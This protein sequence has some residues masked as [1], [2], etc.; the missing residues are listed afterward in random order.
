M[1]NPAGDLKSTFAYGLSRQRYRESP[2]SQSEMYLLSVNKVLLPT[3]SIALSGSRENTSLDG[4]KISTRNRYTFYTDA[5]LY[6]DLTSQLEAVYWDLKNFDYAVVNGNQ[7]N[8]NTKMTITSRF[9]PSMS[10]SLSDIYDVHNQTELV[11]K[12]QNTCNLSGNW[13]VSDLLSLNASVTK[14]NG[15]LVHDAYTYST[16]LVAGMGSGW[17]LNASYSLVTA[18][19]KSQSG[20]ASLRWT[21]SRN[22]SWEIGCDYAE[23]DAESTSNVYKFFSQL[24]V[25]FATL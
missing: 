15:N 16:N 13:Q 20:H 10:V 12:R 14:V 6:P 21:A 9:S 1:Q 3:L 11:S 25:N 22:I 19:I 23:T 17:E 24:S 18:E 7:D 5:K 8:F 4:A 2:E